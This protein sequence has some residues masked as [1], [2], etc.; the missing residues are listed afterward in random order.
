[1]SFTRR[2]DVSNLDKSTLISIEH[3]RLTHSTAMHFHNYFELQIVLSGSGRQNLNGTTYPL[4]A[5]T[6]YLLTPTDFHAVEPDPELEIV[7]VAFSESLLSGHL[8]TLFLSHRKDLIFSSLPEAQSMTALV[9]RLEAECATD[10]GY[11]PIARRQLLELL[12]YPVDRNTKVRPALPP[13]ESQRMEKA[14][15]YLSS[16]FRQDISLSDVAAA[17]GYSSNYFS[18]LFHANYGI[19]FV[20]FLSHL[21]INYARTLLLTTDQNISSIAQASGF[22][23]CSN[24]FQAFRKA[25]GL[26]PAEYRNQESARL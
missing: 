14:M 21:R 4:Q 17:S 18:R 3:K 6:V 20:D 9:N 8:Q 5:G 15:Q 22:S 23:S 25:T 11:A 1:M 24:F 10:D 13:S 26:T 19:R 2:N 12:L 16:H 7:H